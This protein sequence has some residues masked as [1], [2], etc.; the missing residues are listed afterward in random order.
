LLMIPAIFWAGTAALARRLQDRVPSAILPIS[1]A[2]VWAGAEY[3]RG[4]VWFLSFP[5]LLVGYSQWNQ[6]TV[7]Q[8]AS[9]VGVYGLSALIV[10]VNGALADWLPPLASAGRRAAGLAWVAA[11][12]ALLWWGR[13]EAARWRVEAE[14]GRTVIVAAIQDESYNDVRLAAWTRQAA[15]ADPKPEIVVWPE[16]S[17]LLPPGHEAERIA[18]LRTR[19]REVRAALVIGCVSF[20]GTRP[21][22]VTAGA[23]LPAVAGVFSRHKK[24]ENF[25]LVLGP[26]GSELG[27]YWKT[28]PIPIVEAWVARGTEFPVFNLPAVK[29]GI[30]I[31]YDLD[32]EDGAR[33]V[34]ANGAELLLVPNLAPQYWGPWQHRL[35]SA[36]APLRA[37]E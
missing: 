5:W 3:F 14:T 1:V 30:Q 4:E 20:R 37:V 27:R 13:G 25:A 18:A 12:L 11:A 36:M 31:C 17:T 34:V 28:H 24:F 2:A 21:E 35:H 19:A 6:E 16:Y 7:L 29:T 26:D 33:K 10:G 8:G 15:K 32:A 9:L 22:P 23:G